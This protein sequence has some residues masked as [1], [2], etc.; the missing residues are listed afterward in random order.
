MYPLD[1]ATKCWEEARRADPQKAIQLLRA[2]IDGDSRLR[3][4]ALLFA[5]T[6]WLHQAGMP[7]PTTNFAG[8]FTVDTNK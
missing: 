2:K 8:S 4:E 3:E 6:E 1:T 5:A 7:R